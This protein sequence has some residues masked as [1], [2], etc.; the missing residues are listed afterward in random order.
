MKKKLLILV[1]T[2]LTIFIT[3]C[4]S[5]GIDITVNKDGSGEIVQTFKVLK[6]YTAFMNLE[7]ESNTDPNMINEME[8]GKI[9]TAMGKGVT[10]RKVEPMSEESLYAGYKAY[11]DFTDISKVKTSITPMMAPG[12][13][14]TEESDL[15]SFDFKQ[16]KT[17]ILTIISYPEM[18]EDSDEYPEEDLETVDS[19]MSDEG[20]MEQFKQAY[21]TMHFWFK[22]KVNGTISDSNAFY[23]DSSTATIMDMNFEKI[24]ENDKLFTELTSNQN[25]D[26]DKYKEELEKIGVKIDDQEIIEIKFK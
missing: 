14:E 7:D 1:I 3:G 20:M 19:E 13:M 16:G 18:E 23:T 15:V 5:S 26:L 2:M 8:L 25:S 24:V 17:S 21:K 22:V 11:F 10:L 4:L 9:A 6:E 12:M